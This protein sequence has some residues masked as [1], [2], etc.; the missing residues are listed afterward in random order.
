MTTFAWPAWIKQAALQN[1]YGEEPEV[2]V[3]SFQPE[4]GPAKLRR[5]T[6]MPNETMTFSYQYDAS[7]WEDLKNF[8]K[9]TLSDGTQPFTMTHPR[10]GTVATWVF[11]AAPKVTQTLGPLFFTIQFALRLL[12]GGG[13]PPA[14]K[15][16]RGSNTQLIGAF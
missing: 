14:L 8:Y 15:F 2:N 12:S 11:T 3:A 16:N 1:G 7:D 10:T 4:V 5:R 9:G 13:L 6:S